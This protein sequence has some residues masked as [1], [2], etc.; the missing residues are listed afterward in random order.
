MHDFTVLVLEGANPSSVAATHDILAAAGVLAKRTGSTA[1]RWRMCSID[2]GRIPLQG[3]FGIDTSRLPARSK[4]D[5]STWVLPG[6]GYATPAALQARLDS[7]DA[8]DAINALARHVKQGGRVAASCSAVFVLHA[9]GLLEGRRVTT[10]WWLAPL[11]KQMAPE[12]IVDADRMVCIDGPITTAGAAFAQTDLMLHLLRECSGSALVD[13]VSRTLLIDDRQAQAPFIVAELQ[14]GGN[15]LVTRIAARIES[16]LP[17]PPSVLALA[18][19]YGMSERTLS[20]HIHR[21]TGKSTVALVQNIKLRRARV[22]LETSRM[23]VEQV[24]EAV[25]YRD[26]TALRRLM[27]KRSGANPSRYRPAVATAIR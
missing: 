6:L 4:H 5:R 16:A 25:G 3:G 15:E 2:G 19:E 24:A 26:S 18:Q 13:A 23:T 8:I 7:A 12:C 17:N 20:R 14:A 9:A 21:A 1:P 10:T 27:K 11:L 22:L